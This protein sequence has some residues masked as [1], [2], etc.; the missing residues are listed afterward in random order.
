MLLALAVLLLIISIGSVHLLAGK[1]DRVEVRTLAVS[2]ANRHVGLALL[3][4]ERYMHARH[5]L[6]A[7]A[8]YAI[9]VAVMMVLA[10]R[11]FHIRKLAV[12]KASA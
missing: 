2:N 9:I 6:P 1:L 10:S 12:Q 7:V 8:C 4:S 3:L 11:I 5:A